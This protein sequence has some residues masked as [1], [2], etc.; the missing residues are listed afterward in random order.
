MVP[1]IVQ[2]ERAIATKAPYFWISTLAAALMIAATGFW[3]KQAA[4]YSESKAS[5]ITNK[6]AEL[7]KI[8]DQIGEQNKRLASI[9]KRSDPY[10]SAI[11][12]RVYWIETFRELNDAMV[13]DKVWFVQLQPLSGELTLLP[14]A[15]NSSGDVLEQ[16]AL[17]QAGAGQ[18]KI[19]W[20][21]LKG[22]WRDNDAEQNRVVYKYLDQ[23]RQSKN[24]RFDIAERDEFGDLTRDTDGNIVK[25]YSD[26]ELLPFLN[27]GTSGDRHAWPFTLRLPLPE[28]YQLQYT[29]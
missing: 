14:E 5:E 19:D 8:D 27:M 29:K 17:A 4:S 13:D 11:F 22:L 2:R 3:L 7:Q 1:P 18:H 20:I 15:G 28:G 24:G 23:L 21:E 26:G 16:G 6:V 10:S 25:K 9:K 12:D